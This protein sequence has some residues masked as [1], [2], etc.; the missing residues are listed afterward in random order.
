MIVTEEPLEGRQADPLLH[1]G[2]AERV[3]EYVRAHLPADARAVR[4]YADDALNGPNA[5]A[6]R[7]RGA[8]SVARSTAALRHRS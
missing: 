3:L 1:G 6:Q 4:D 7:R 8:R 2:N 5:H